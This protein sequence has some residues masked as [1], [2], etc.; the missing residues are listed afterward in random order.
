MPTYEYK[1]LGCD[2]R[3]DVFQSMTADPLTECDVCHGQLKRLIGAGAGIIFKGSGFYATDYRSDSYRQSA[4]T[5]NTATSTTPTATP[6]APA[7]SKDSS[8][9]GGE[10][11]T[12]AS[13]PAKGD[14]TT[15]KSLTE[16]P[17]T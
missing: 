2:R 11:A 9:G 3:F 16:G 8:T 5:D 14:S 12:P 6:A 13:S 10:K 15:K 7:A 1:C 17:K 4:K